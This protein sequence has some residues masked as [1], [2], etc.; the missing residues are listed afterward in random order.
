MLHKIEQTT[1][2][3]GLIGGNM[4]YFLFF[5]LG[6]HTTYGYSDSAGDKVD[7]KEVSIKVVDR[8]DMRKVICERV[9]QRTEIKNI[10]IKQDY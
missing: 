4:A 5:I 2:L 1:I 7:P 8:F 3:K 9:S 6:F 10:K